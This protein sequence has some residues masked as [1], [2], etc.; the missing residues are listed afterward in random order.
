MLTAIGAQ[1]PR[2]RPPQSLIASTAHELGARCGSTSSFSISTQ[3]FSAK[4]IAFA[5]Y[6]ARFL[7]KYCGGNVAVFPCALPT[8]E[9]VNRTGRFGG[10][11]SFGTLPR[12]SEDNH[13]NRTGLEAAHHALNVNAP[14][15]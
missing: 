4:R 11:C 5:T 15:T 9:P 1:P 2:E 12:A 13:S 3:V 7:T 8:W 14:C 10:A 6:F